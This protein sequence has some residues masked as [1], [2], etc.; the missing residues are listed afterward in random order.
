MYTSSCYGLPSESLNTLECAVNSVFPKGKSLIV[1]S[2][3]LIFDENIPHGSCQL[4]AY[5]AT[6]HG[7]RLMM[8]RH[9][10]LTFHIFIDGVSNLAEVHI[11]LGI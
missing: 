5:N 1:A 4:I 2:R 7:E 10:H 8:G 6:C 11:N 3:F 9:Q